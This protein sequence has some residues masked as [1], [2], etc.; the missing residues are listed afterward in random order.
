M[1]TRHGI[2]AKICLYWIQKSLCWSGNISAI[3]CP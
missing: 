1:Y 3:F 2:E